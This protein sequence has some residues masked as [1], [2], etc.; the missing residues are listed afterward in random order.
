MSRPSRLSEPKWG[1]RESP[2]SCF[3]WRTIGLRGLMEIQQTLSESTYLSE[4]GL[5]K[6]MVKI[7]WC[8]QRKIMVCTQEASRRGGG[9]LMGTSHDPHAVFRSQFLLGS[10][11]GG[12]WLDETGPPKTPVEI[13][14]HLHNHLHYHPVQWG[15]GVW[16]T[17]SGT[18][19]VL[20]KNQL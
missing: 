15:E 1:V 20:I 4:E 2:N 3:P 17:Q 8:K 13:P 14:Y 10:G 16:S 9:A 6:V 5:W 11:T 18:R 12:S 19:T 7:S